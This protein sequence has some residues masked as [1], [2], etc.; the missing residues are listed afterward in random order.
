MLPHERAHAA[1][2]TIWNTFPPPSLAPLSRGRNKCGDISGKE[3]RL[4]KYCQVS[5]VAPRVPKI[6]SWAPLA[7]ACT[8]LIKQYVGGNE[9]ENG[10]TA[11]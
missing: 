11:I 3:E 7:P 9:S 10:R 5:Y 6:P 8:V 2:G 1:N 4:G